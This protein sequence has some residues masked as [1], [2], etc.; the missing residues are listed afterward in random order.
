MTERPK[1]L[2]TGNGH[3]LTLHDERLDQLDNRIQVDE[4]WKLTILV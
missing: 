2:H 1:R 4:R 3:S